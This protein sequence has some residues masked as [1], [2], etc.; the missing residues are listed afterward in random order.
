MSTSPL[1]VLI[2]TRDRTLRD[3]LAR[4]LRNRFDFETVA[5]AESIQLTLE[6]CSE[7]RTDIILFDFNG[8][9]T[10]S[11]NEI[12][13]LR[14]HLPGT[15]IVVLAHPQELAVIGKLSEAGASGWLLKGTSGDRIANALRLGKYRGAITRAT[16]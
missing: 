2:V 12:Q 13:A 14:F 7:H 9:V 11:I 16:C 4:P 5:T 1:K 15:P 8:Y 10:S 6:K 3:S